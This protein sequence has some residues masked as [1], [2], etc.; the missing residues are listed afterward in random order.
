MMTALTVTASVHTDR[1]WQAGILSNSANCLE[2]STHV[3]QVNAILLGRP[4]LVRKALKLFYQWTFF[5]IFYQSTVL[6]SRTVNGH[7]IYFEGSVVGKALIIGIDIS[8]TL[9]LSFT[10][11]QKVRNLASF[12]ISLN[13]RSKMQQDIGNLK[14]KY[15]AAMIA[16]CP[17]QVW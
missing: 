5:F 16:L 7:Q 6:S 4:T 11:G 3:W 9:S 17:C 2:L 10:R 1:G 15:Y 13:R 12:K 14:Q 8:P